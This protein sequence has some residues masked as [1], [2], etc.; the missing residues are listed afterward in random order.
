[1]TSTYRIRFVIQEHFWEW[2]ELLGNYKRIAASLWPHWFSFTAF[3]GEIPKAFIDLLASQLQQQQLP[4][5][6]TLFVPCLSAGQ[7]RDMKP[8]DGDGDCC[9]CGCCCWGCC[10]CAIKSKGRSNTATPNAKYATCGGS[11]HSM[12]LAAATRAKMASEQG[13][14][15]LGA[16]TLP[17]CL[18]A[19]LPGVGA[20]AGASA[21]AERSRLIGLR[22]RWR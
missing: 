9:C 17:A 16:T 3:F 18:P 14:F 15:L 4:L 5:S 11:S 8:I 10:C 13:G 6:P 19:C 12:S 2:L 1:M 22:R 20:G 21:G 7:G